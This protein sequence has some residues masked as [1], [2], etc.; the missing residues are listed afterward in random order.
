MGALAFALLDS[1]QSPPSARAAVRAPARAAA[2]LAPAPRG[3]PATLQLG[4]ASG[5]GQGGALT[6]YGPLGSAFADSTCACDAQH[7]GVTNP[8]PIDG[9][10]GVASSSDD[11]GGYFRA[12]ARV[13][14]RAGALRLPR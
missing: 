7:D 11:G 6:G 12:Q 13:Y 5:L 3:W 9:N 1:H 10:T 2:A 8:A 4:L 14:Y